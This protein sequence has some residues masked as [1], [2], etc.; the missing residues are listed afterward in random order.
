MYIHF[1]KRTLKLSSV[2]VIRFWILVI[3]GTL[4]EISLWSDLL[5]IIV[6]DKT[7]RAPEFSPGF[8]GVPVTRSLVLCVCF[9]VR[10][11]SFRTFSFGHCVV[12]SS[13][14]YGLWLRLWYLQ[15]LLLTIYSGLLRRQLFPLDVYDSLILN[16]LFLLLS[17]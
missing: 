8:S 2:Y 15:T 12:C 13:S 16:L 11:L 4:S 14:I 5:V 9:V 10:R 7:R 1:N 17:K 6:W 3:H